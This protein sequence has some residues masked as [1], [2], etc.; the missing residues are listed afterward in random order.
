MEYLTPKKP[1]Y[2]P[3]YPY[4][5]R[6]GIILRMESFKRTRLP[7]GGSQVAIDPWSRGIPFTDIQVHEEP[8]S[9]TKL[10][11]KNIQ[12]VLIK[13]EAWGA[14]SLLLQW[15][16]PC[17]KTNAPSVVPYC[18]RCSASRPAPGDAPD[19]ENGL[20]WHQARMEDL[21]RRS[22]IGPIH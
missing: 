20:V 14:I 17:P 22:R 6:V 4:W 3:L 1:K 8:T 19:R 2:R 7:S 18:S 12:G 10:R 13:A 21:L 15:I 5:V 9:R 11:R 16:L